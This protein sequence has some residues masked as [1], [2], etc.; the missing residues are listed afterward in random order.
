MT[1]D[2]NFFPGRFVYDFGVHYRHFERYMR[3]IK[4]LG[5]LGKGET[6]L[7]CAC[8]S[9][10]GSHLLSG[11]AEKVIGFD[12]NKEAVAYAKAKYAHSG[13][14]FYSDVTGF[15]DV[16]FDA[17]ISVETIEHMPRQEAV[18]FLKNIRKQMK[19]EA[20]M[21]ITTPIV[22]E[23]N[24]NP[25]NPF[26]KYEYSYAEFSTLLQKSG[27]TID[28]YEADTVTFT[29]GETKDQGYFRCIS[30]G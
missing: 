16:I 10:Y 12:I 2:E 24:P 5:K 6:W 9:G 11:F 22:A 4:V 27:F 18:F 21:V 19:E 1:A 8:G 14:F 17:V 13:L 20:I 25:T 28:K 29:D 3:A 7:D 15:A 30:R 26:H 23:S